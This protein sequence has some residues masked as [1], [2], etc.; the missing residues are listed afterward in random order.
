MTAAAV[1]WLSPHLRHVEDPE[2][3]P[4]PAPPLPG[5]ADPVPAGMEAA[6]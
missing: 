1:A 3:E 5:V 2:P 4:G 6:R